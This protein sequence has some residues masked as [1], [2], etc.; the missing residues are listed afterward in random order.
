MAWVIVIAGIFVIGLAAGIVA[1]ASYGIRHEQRRFRSMRRFEEEHGVADARQRFLGEEAPD[2][3]SWAAR[4]LNG[5]YVRDSR[6]PELHDAD[7][8]MPV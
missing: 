8:E 3:V 6:S 4:R 7:Q 2:G 1:V 5:L